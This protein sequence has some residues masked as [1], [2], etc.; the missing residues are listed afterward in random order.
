MIGSGII[1]YPASDVLQQSPMSGGTFS[2][3][4]GQHGHS[5]ADG[6]A[7]S[8]NH[9]IGLLYRRTSMRLHD[10]PTP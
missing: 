4:F 1:P 3:L 6:A 2:I 5:I 9:L 8:C 10:P 7:G